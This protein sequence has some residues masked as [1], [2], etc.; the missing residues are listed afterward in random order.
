MS[1][2]SQIKPAIGVYYNGLRVKCTKSLGYI[3]F[4]EYNST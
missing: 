1:L 3:F 2:N 4:N